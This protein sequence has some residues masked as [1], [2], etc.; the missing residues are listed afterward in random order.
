VCDWSSD[1]CFPILCVCVC[2]S[3]CVVIV[4]AWI[5]IMGCEDMMMQGH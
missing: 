2:V 1:V 3:E 4:L 5:G